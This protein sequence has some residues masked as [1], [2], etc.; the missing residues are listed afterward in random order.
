MP[1]PEI[2]EQTNN[3]RTEQV[4]MEQDPNPRGIG[5]QRSTKL[6]RRCGILVFYRTFVLLISSYNSGTSCTPHSYHVTIET[7]GVDELLSTVDFISS[8]LP[9]IR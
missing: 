7:N 4:I 8:V 9:F 5:I 3:Y 6:V 1:V 2:I